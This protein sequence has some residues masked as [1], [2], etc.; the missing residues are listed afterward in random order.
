MRI[1]GA[2]CQ[3]TACHCLLLLLAAT[4]VIELQSCNA[5][6]EWRCSRSEGWNA[7]VCGS[8][9]QCQSYDLAVLSVTLESPHTIRKHLSTRHTSHLLR[10]LEE[11]QRHL[12]DGLDGWILRN[13]RPHRIWH[14]HEQLLHY[15]RRRTACTLVRLYNM[16]KLSHLWIHALYMWIHMESMW[17]HTESMWIHTAS[18]WIHTKFVW[19]RTFYMWI[20]TTSMHSLVRSKAATRQHNDKN[21]SVPIRS[22]LC[23]YGENL[24]TTTTA[25]GPATGI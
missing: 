16:D 24:S 2:A 3:D 4:S 15:G 11:S 9:A 7:T 5:S 17:I 19:I 8:H 13:P 18:I 22:S 20:Y 1:S 10:S 23:L 21:S 6:Q 14:Q 12:L 25:T